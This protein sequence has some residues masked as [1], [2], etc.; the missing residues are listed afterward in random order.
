MQKNSRYIIQEFLY[1][2]SY[3]IWREKKEE[4]SLQIRALISDSTNTLTELA[5][6][7]ALLV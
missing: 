1:R 3:I 7:K 6:K 4:G 2:A 5:L